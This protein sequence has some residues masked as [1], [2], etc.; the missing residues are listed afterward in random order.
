M[1]HQIGQIIRAVSA[2]AC[3][4]AKAPKN[5]VS[6]AIGESLKPRWL[7]FEVTD[8]CNSRCKHCNIWRNKPTK[9]VLTPQ[10]IKKTLN[11]DLFRRVEC[12]NLTGGEPVLRHDL[13]EVILAIHETLPKASVWLSTNGLLPQ[14]VVNAVQVA[15][16]HDI[17]FGVGVS[18][19]GIGE[20]HDSIRGVKG[21]FEKVDY[22]LHELIALNKKHGGKI[23]LAV[24]FVLSD[25]T[26]PSLAEV[27]AYAQRLNV[28]F[29]P[30]MYDEAPFYD[31]DNVDY[32]NAI[33][34]NVRAL[35]SDDLIKAVQS[36]RLSLHRD[37]WLRAIMGKSIKFPCFALYTFCLLR[38]NGDIAPCLRLGDTRVGN[39][40]EQSPSSIWHSS[41]AKKARRLVKGCDGCLNDWGIDWSFQS[42]YLPILSFIIRHP[43]VV[44]GRVRQS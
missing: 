10:E 41:A 19:D 8:A 11:D 4:A 37:V 29:I 6:R 20:K 36:L 3:M 25:L 32:K 26:L 12:I 21:N 34:Y 1:K 24:G 33:P 44:I 7:V 30:Q 16:E 40:K 35:A 17:N 18:L 15:L 28:N 14:R 23:H 5:M 39:V 43:R 27:Q 13:E 42:S 9:D 22:L 2:N 38:C 31:H